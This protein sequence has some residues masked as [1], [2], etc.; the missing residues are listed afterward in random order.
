MDGADLVATGDLGRA[1]PRSQR[2]WWW[3]EVVFEGVQ[4]SL[5]WGGGAVKVG[6]Q[7]ILWKSF[8]LT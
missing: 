5:T 7:E 3:S 1:I 6:R 4:G 2:W 8:A